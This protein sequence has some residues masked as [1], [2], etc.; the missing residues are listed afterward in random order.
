MEIAA[1]LLLGTTAMLAVALVAAYLPARRASIRRWRCSTISGR[2]RP[3]ARTHGRG[4]L[5]I[6]LFSS[7]VAIGDAFDGR[8]Q[9]SRTRA[10]LP[11]PRV[12][13]ADP[14]AAGRENARARRARRRVRWPRAGAGAQVGLFQTHDQL[15]RRLGYLL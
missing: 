6:V 7:P 10:Q 3:A 15:L 9:P 11:S 8:G 4:A 13:L 5:A 2:P 12:T 14:D 1:P